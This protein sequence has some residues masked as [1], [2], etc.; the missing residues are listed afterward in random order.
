MQDRRDV[1]QERCRTGEMQDRCDE[2]QEGCRTGG[3][4]DRRDAGQVGCT[5][6]GGLQLARR[7]EY[8]TGGLRTD[9]I[10]GRTG[11]IQE[12]WDAGR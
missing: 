2:G 5:I 12:R 10:Q 6:G 11:R 3:M 4:R 7:V 8:R 1:G 9:G